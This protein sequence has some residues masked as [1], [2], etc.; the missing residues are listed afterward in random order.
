MNRYPTI[1]HDRPKIED[2]CPYRRSIG[3]HGSA[4]IRK[5]WQFFFFWNSRGRN[6]RG[7]SQNAHQFPHL[8]PK[9]HPCKVNAL[10]LLTLKNISNSR[11]LLSSD[12]GVSIHR[13][14]QPHCF[15]SHMILQFDELHSRMQWINY[16]CVHITCVHVLVSDK[17]TTNWFRRLESLSYYSLSLSIYSLL[18]YQ[19]HSRVLKF[20]IIKTVY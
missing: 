13:G 3:F 10:D 7:Y 14:S 5:A 15:T 16:T 1:N 18:G 11:E 6:R 8:S 9:R 20:L 4:L 12:E 2:W 17:K 19:Y